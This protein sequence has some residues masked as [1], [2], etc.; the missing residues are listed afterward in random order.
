VTY[1]RTPRRGDF[2]AQLHDGTG[3]WWTSPASVDTGFLGR[4]GL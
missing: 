3:G 1:G 4:L 2:W